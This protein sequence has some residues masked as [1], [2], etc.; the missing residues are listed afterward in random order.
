MHQTVLA[1]RPE[2]RERGPRAATTN[3]SV[4]V[5]DDDRNVLDLIQYILEAEG[6]SVVTAE[7]GY[8]ALIRAL[9]RRPS[10]VLLDLRLPHLSGEIVARVLRDTYAEALPIVVMSGNGE[11][12]EAAQRVGADGYL[13]KPFTVTGI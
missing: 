9:Y 3:Q 12:E 11:V 4:L 10:L 13:N 6:L 7:D 5:V 8:Q 2:E 1:T